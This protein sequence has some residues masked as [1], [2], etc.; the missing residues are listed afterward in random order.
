MM[1]A[2]FHMTLLLFFLLF[3]CV[4]SLNFQ[5]PRFDPSATNMVYQR[6]VVPAVGADNL[7]DKNDF[8]CRVGRATYAEKVLLWDSNNPAR[9]IDFTTHF[10]FSIITQGTVNG[11]G[12]AFFL[13]RVKFQIPSNSTGGFLGLFDPTTS[14][15]TQNQIVT[16]EFDTYSNPEWD[17]PFEHVGINNTSIASAVYTRWNAS[18]HSG[19]NTDVSIS[20]NASTKNLSVSWSYENSTRENVTSLSYQIDLAKI[21]P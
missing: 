14:D 8:F 5:M 10:S 19:E 20:Y 1:I 17:P 18:L 3:P 4:D 15:S 13:T 11:H 7:I 2:F 16:V 9:T 6:D 12:I 21:F